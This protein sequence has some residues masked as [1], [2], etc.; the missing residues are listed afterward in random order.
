MEMTDAKVVEKKIYEEGKKHDDY[1]SK[2]TGNAGLTLGII[3]TALGAG[4]LG[5][6]AV[7]T[8]AY[9]AHSAAICLR[10]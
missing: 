1:A 10:T 2:A 6:L 4:A 3:G 5:C 9:L 8:A 7:T